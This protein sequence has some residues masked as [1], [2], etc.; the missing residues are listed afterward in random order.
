MKLWGIGCYDKIIMFKAESRDDV[1]KYIANHW[2]DQSLDVLRSLMQYPLIIV[3]N[4]AD[5]YTF[6]H[7]KE[8][9]ETIAD[10]DA[11]DSF[12]LNEATEPFYCSK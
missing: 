2:S 5:K 11:W 6:E 4:G 3:S 1:Y 9:F 7:I 10:D 8:A 12:E